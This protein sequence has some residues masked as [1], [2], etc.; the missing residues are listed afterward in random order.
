MVTKEHSFP[1]TLTMI[2]GDIEEKHDDFKSAFKRLYQ[3]V[4]KRIAKGQMTLNELETT[5]F[6]KEEKTLFPLNFYTARDRA[7]DEGLLV[8]RQLTY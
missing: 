8:N 4:Q 1:C 6:I 7:Y 5:I 2:S 3:E